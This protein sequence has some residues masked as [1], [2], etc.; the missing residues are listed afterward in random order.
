MWVGCRWMVISRVDSSAV[1]I[2][3]TC[4]QAHVLGQA[5]NQAFPPIFHS[6]VRCYRRNRVTSHLGK[7]DDPSS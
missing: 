3:I 2:I 5:C 6:E 7:P 1:S 4:H